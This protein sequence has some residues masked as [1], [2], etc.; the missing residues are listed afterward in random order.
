MRARLLCLAI[1]TGC[2]AGPTDPAPASAAPD[3]TA[4]HPSPPAVPGPDDGGDAPSTPDADTTPESEPASVP[5]VP[6]PTPTEPD[7]L[8]LDTTHSTSVGS[9]TSGKL[10][11]SVALPREAPGLQLLPRKGSGSR[12]GTFE[13]VQ[14]LVRAAAAV[15]EASPGAPVSLGD[16]SRQDGGDISGHASHRSGRDVDVLFY[17][18]R[19]DGKP[20][21]PAKFIPLDPDGRGTDYGDLT[22]PADDVPVH[23]DVARTWLFVAALLADTTAS[24][25]RILV[26]EHLRSLLLAEAK[27]VG[28]PPAVVQRFSDVTCQPRFPHDD[29][30]HIRVFCS[31]D[32]IGAG[33]EDT[34][35]V[36]P[37]RARELKA[38]G[39][40]AVL[41]GR[42]TAAAD[43]TKRK[44]KLKTLEQARAEAGPMHEDV[45]EFLD[46]RK[47]W[48]KKPRPGR[49]WCR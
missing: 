48:A 14:G 29:H 44:P 18:L 25:Q 40:K 26:V 11:G 42:N 12:Y 21:T 30:M 37:W 35:P 10:E 13:L 9:P 28:A 27:R 6:P 17:L 2:G 34:P 33:C 36:F 32:D 38:Q 3:P 1:A 16:L 47:A 41:A 24:V 15:D 39:T 23:I 4:P 43:T 8:T 7:P 5:D 31:A 22:D 19:D 45:V 20:F 49:R 46:R